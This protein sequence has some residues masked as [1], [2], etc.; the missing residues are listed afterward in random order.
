M[1]DFAAI[2]GENPASVRSGRPRL[3]S[4]GGGLLAISAMS[5]IYGFLVP[6]AR[7]VHLGL[8]GF[9]L[10]AG[11]FLWAG[12]NLHALSYSRTT[13]ESAF[14]GE[15]FPLTLTIKNSRKREDAFAVAFADSVAGT[16]EV[17]LCVD[18]LQAGDSAT[19]EMQA[20]LPR[21]GLLHRAH[22][23]F[24]S[25]FPLGL[26]SS[27]IEL[28][29]SLQMT[30]FPRPIPP[31]MFE[32]PDVLTL[33][34]ADDAESA[35]TDWD[36]D[37]HGLR[38]FQP[39][40]PMKS[41]HWPASTRSRHL[42]VRQYDRRQPSRV[43]ILFHSIRPDLKPQPGEAFESAMELLCGMLHYFLRRGTPVDM[44]ASFNQWQSLRVESQQDLYAALCTLAMAKRTTERNCDAL[45]AALAGSETGRR[46]II[47]SDVPL[48]VWE[49]DM[50]EL[51]GGTICLSNE[52][53]YIRQPRRLPQKPIPASKV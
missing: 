45:H 53:I 49:R 4:R 23:S 14:A 24:E 51:P 26:W 35:M 50:L 41:I 34:D 13:P 39:G 36:G 43:T 10:L 31:K 3:T 18:W 11:S 12:R 48:K 7:L 30:I 44:I 1:S 20:R 21:R 33:L 47:L 6:E 15:L 2:P 25:S 17:G 5:V 16:T 29:S 28:T 9:L 27:R 52:E 19:R 8:L 37:F 38:E 46:V 40:D 42:V 22:S 32:D